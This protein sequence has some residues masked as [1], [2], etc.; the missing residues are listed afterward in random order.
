MTILRCR[1]GGNPLAP[2]LTG[3]IPVQEL[4]KARPL[5]GVASNVAKWDGLAV[6]TISWLRH[7]MFYPYVTISA[8]QAHRSD[9]LRRTM[10]PF[11]FFPPSFSGAQ[12][13]LG[14]VNG[15]VAVRPP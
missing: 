15:V 12:R 8:A 13:I 9:N 11:S 6:R 3:C 1:F 14:Y 2:S 7:R 4:Q 5:K 10:S